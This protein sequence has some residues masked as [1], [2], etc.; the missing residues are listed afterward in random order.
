MMSLFAYIAS[1]SMH[2]KHKGI[3]TA[4]RTVKQA[5]EK[6]GETTGNKLRCCFTDSVF[7][8]RNSFNTMEQNRSIIS[9]NRVG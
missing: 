7:V 6:A 9:V 3:N 1:F 4:G 8:I 2:D 5:V